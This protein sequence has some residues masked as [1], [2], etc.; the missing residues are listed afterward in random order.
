VLSGGALNT[1]VLFD[2]EER[3][4]RANQCGTRFVVP[5][6]LIDHRPPIVEQRS[7]VGDLRKVI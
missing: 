1:V 4:R 6:M 5:V 7:R 2:T 3:R